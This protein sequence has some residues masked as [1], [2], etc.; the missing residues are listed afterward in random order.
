MANKKTNPSE[1]TKKNTKTTSTS[2]KTTTK[3][4]ATK[5]ASKKTTTKK[6][7][8]KP[9]EKT[10]VE[11][12]KKIEAK[13][14]VKEEKITPKKQSEKPINWFKEN[15][16]VIGLILIAI[17]LI[18]NIIIVV[19]GHK[20]KLS[21]GKEIIASL[22]GKEIV[23]EE[24][25]D[26]LKSKYGSDALL[27]LVDDYI[28]DKELSDEEKQDAIKEAK[29]N[30]ESIR[31]Q[32]EEYG[33]EWED[34]LSQYGYENEDALVD[35]FTLSVK[36]ETVAK[37]YLKA[38]LSEDEI[39]KYYDENVFG[40]YSAKHILII[41]DVNDDMSDEEKSAA[42]ENAKNKA[43]EVIE[44]L[45]NGE[46]WAS[47][48]KE[49]SEDEG[50][51]DDEGLVENFTKGDVVDEFWNAVEKLEDGKYTSEPVKSSY[52]YHIIKRESYK[53][54]E[55]LDDMKDELIETII[56]NKLSEDSN[57]YTSTW[58]EIRKKH[59]FEINDTIIKNAYEK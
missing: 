49:Y 53:E 44:K 34:V 6:V 37:N 5:T 11:A 1:S 57:L 8:T 32:Y 43:K 23:A 20:V 42:E 58:V 16:V 2:K 29:E 9:V 14:I 4:A 56:N 38:N 13:P 19:N 25:F 17:L 24:L 39:K 54:K 7:Q 26:N 18:I 50:S 41:P 45:N 48:V 59:N 27:N 55:K 15:Y 33:Y 40:T 12:T 35:E 31:S 52:G 10:K 30:V 51:I 21:D 3:K 47:L 46:D 36:K 28:A 22:D